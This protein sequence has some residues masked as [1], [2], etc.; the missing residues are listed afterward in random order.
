MTDLRWL[1]QRAWDNGGQVPKASVEQLTYKMGLSGSTCSLLFCV[2]LS[3][4]EYLVLK[5][6]VQGKQIGEIL[7]FY[8]SYCRATTPTQDPERPKNTAFTRAVFEKFARTSPWIPVPWVKGPS[9][10]CSKKLA[11][12]NSFI[13]CDFWGVDFLSVTRENKAPNI[14][15]AIL[16]LVV[17]ETDFYP[18]AAL[19]KLRSPYEGAT[20]QPSTG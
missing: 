11:Q 19:G 15:E 16:P 1:G 20:P 18:V 14:S 12:M 4:L 6:E 3:D 13:M 10:N 5:G 2:A 9:R 17:W 7:Q 8:E